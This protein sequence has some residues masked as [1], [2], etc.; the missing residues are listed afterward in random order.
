MEYNTERPHSAL[1]YLTPQQFAQAH[2]VKQLLTSDSKAV[3]D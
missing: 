2:E 1:G 3:S